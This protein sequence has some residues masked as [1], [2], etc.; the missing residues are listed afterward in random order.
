MANGKIDLSVCVHED[1]LCEML[2][3]GIKPGMGSRGWHE[4]VPQQGR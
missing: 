3:G 1:G 4:A 2:C